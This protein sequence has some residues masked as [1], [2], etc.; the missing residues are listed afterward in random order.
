MSIID[1]G[2]KKEVEKYFKD[3]TGEVNLTVF[4]RNSA[5]VVPGYDC[6]ACK[7]NE[8]LIQEIAALSDKLNFAMYDYLKDKHKVEEYHIDKIPVTLV[9]GETDPGIR[10]FGIP[11]GHEFSALLHAIMIVSTGDH[12]LSRET[13]EM[14]SNVTDPVHI[15]VFVT[16]SCPYCAP[17]VKVA[18]SMTIDNP[19]ITADMI[20]ANDF[21]ELAQRYNVF[22]VPKIVINE[23]SQIEGALNETAFAEKLVSTLSV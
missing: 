16:P 23:H 6:P 17:V 4:S 15:Q 5:I 9:H 3:L 11:S 8:T 22:T 21:P 18:H 7:D 12:G 19:H 10:F 14:L 13:T 20:N 2:I 1:D